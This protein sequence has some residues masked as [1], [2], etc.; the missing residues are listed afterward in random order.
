MPKGELQRIE[1]QGEGLLLSPLRVM[2]R[3]SRGL[4]ILA[5][6]HIG[7]AAHF[8]R[9]GIPAPQEADRAV[10]E[11]LEEA[12]ARFEPERIL[13]LGDLAHSVKNREWDRFIEWR[14]ARPSISFE[15]IVGNHDIL[16]AKQYE[17][18]GVRLLQ[19][20]YEEG[21]F[22]LHHH[23]CSA[24]GAEQYALSGHLHPGC[25]VGKRKKERV[26]LPCF[27]FGPG[28]ALLPSFNPFA[29]TARI[30]AGPNDPIYLV[31]DEAL[32]PWLASGDKDAKGSVPKKP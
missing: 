5:D 1:W 20:G 17:A 11:R 21:G 7:K 9:N 28:G 15:L 31:T 8:R 26:T 29:G 27:W 30:Q 14:N 12:C 23:P 6:P 10:I 18:A 22:H 4:L 32:V 16:P 25:R 3:P 19:A 13:V 2:V 24:F